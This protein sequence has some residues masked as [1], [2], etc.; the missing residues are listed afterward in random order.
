MTNQGKL[1]RMGVDAAVAATLILAGLNT[2]RKIKLASDELIAR[3]GADEDSKVI[4][5]RAQ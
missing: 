1:V 2:P 3:C 4:E 5:W